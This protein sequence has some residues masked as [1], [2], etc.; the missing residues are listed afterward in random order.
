MKEILL[1]FSFLFIL[2]CTKGDLLIQDT[3][4]SQNLD[5]YKYNPGGLVTNP[6]TSASR[7]IQYKLTVVA[8]EGGWVNFGETSLRLR[9]GYYIYRPAG[10]EV[11]VSATPAEGYEFSGWSNGWTANPITFKLNSNIGFSANFT[12]TND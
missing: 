9:D 1:F 7:N 12:N 5:T 3:S 6:I 2:S 4:A 11:T 10:T 8:N